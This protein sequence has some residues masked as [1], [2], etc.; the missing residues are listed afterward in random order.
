MHPVILP[1][2]FALYSISKLISRHDTLKKG[3][4]ENV[5]DKSKTTREKRCLLFCMNILIVQRIVQHDI[6]VVEE[7]HL[8]THCKTAYLLLLLFNL[9]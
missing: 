1:Y 8:F 6:F 9:L 3:K 2:F 4:E 5:D 7:Y